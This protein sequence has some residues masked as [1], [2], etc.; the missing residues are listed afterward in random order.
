[1]YRNREVHHAPLRPF[2]L[3]GPT[4]DA[5]DV[6]PGKIE[7]PEDIRAGDYLEFSNIGAYSLAGRTRFNQHYSDTIVCIGD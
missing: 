4:C 2:T 7:L 1:M 3:F 5:F 6:L